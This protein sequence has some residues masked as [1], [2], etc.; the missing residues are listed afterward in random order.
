MDAYLESLVKKDGDVTE[1][2]NDTVDET[3]VKTTTEEQIEEPAKEEPAKEEPFVEEVKEEP[4]EEELVV[5]KPTKEEKKQKKTKSS[6]VVLEEGKE[7]DVKP[8]RIYRTPDLHQV[9]F[10]FEGRL[11]Y[12]GKIETFSII[13]YMKHGFGLVQ[14][15]VNNLEE[16]VILK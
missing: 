14:G 1:A 12:V 7:Y 13:K 9:S 3:I 6:N 5:E 10:Q 16:A 8:V 11:V 4:V 15:Y 2:K